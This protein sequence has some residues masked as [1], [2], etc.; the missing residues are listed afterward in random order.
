M[1]WPA[2]GDEVPVAAPCETPRFR[3]PAIAPQAAPLSIAAQSAEPGRHR[4]SA[5]PRC[6]ILETVQAVRDHETVAGSNSSTLYFPQQEEAGDGQ[7]AGMRGKWAYIGGGAALSSSPAV[8]A[9]QIGT[10]R[11]SPDARDAARRPPAPPPPAPPPAAPR[12]PP[13]ER[14]PR[15]RRGRRSPASTAELAE[16]EAENAR[17]R[18]TLAVRDAVLESLQGHASPSATPPLD[19]LRP[20]RR[21]RRRSSRRCRPRSIAGAAASP[22]LRGEAIAALKPTGEPSAARLEAGPRR[23]RATST[24][25]SPPSQRRA[26]PWAL[27]AAGR[28][29]EASPRSRSSSTSPAPRLTPAASRAR[30]RRRGLARRHDARA[31]S[32]SSATPTASAAPPPTAASPT[33]APAPS[34]TR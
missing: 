22:Q 8:A 32:A 17:L 12:R 20:A 30:R 2:V 13:A 18:T 15:R 9:T 34:P 25:S 21:Q 28:R 29:P 27:A 19:D 33:A 4:H 3:R 31:R 10:S 16:Q 1:R 6:G 24:R 23:G 26:A 11:P 5:G 14:R 7:G